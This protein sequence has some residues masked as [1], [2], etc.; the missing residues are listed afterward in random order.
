ML[1][2]NV[3]YM[4]TRSVGQQQSN[5][6]TTTATAIKTLTQILSKPSS[7]TSVHPTGP[8]PCH[9]HPT[10]VSLDVSADIAADSLLLI[11]RLNAW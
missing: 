3:A 5:H 9:T 1:T 6:K 10:V 8:T 7:A 2:R 4:C 11:V